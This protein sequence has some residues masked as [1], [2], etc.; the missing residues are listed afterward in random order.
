M[1]QAG[2][3]AIEQL[4]DRKIQQISKVIYHLN[5]KDEDADSL[6]GSANTYENEIEG[7]LRD[8]SERVR[9]FH[10]ACS[11]KNDVNLVEKK[12]REVEQ[13]YEQQKRAALKEFEEYKRKATAQQATAKQEAEAKVGALQRELD[14]QKRD[15]S[16]KMK[17]FVE[18]RRC[19]PHRSAQSGCPRG[20]GWV[21][22]SVPKDGDG[23]LEPQSHP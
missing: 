23:S 15:F 19:S 18:V 9:Q 16:A 21:R 4:M 3:P 6:P 7:I 22:T 8:A 17:Q 1:A 5:A 2:V 20:Q 10:A 14:T 11:H 12:V 13:R